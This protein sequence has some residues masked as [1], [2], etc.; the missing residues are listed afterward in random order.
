MKLSPSAFIVL[1]VSVLPSSAYGYSVFIVAYYLYQAI[2]VALGAGDSCRTSLTELGF[3][4]VENLDCQCQVRS[5]VFNYE[6]FQRCYYSGKRCMLS[7]DIYCG[8]DGILQTQSYGNIVTG[9]KRTFKGYMLLYDV[10]DAFDM[11]FSLDLYNKSCFAFINT[12]AGDIASEN[13]H[14]CDLCETGKDVKFNCS[15]V[16]V[17][18]TGTT[19][20]PG[21]STTSCVPAALIS[22]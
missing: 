13:C 16:D 22:A 9:H 7:S 10:D 20:V 8:M 18:L 17:S 21:P 19:V 11:S 4:V 6:T 14:S 12:F 1:V 5:R 2:Y 3:D 15:N